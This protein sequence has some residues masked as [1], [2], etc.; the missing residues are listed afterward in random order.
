MQ[1]S[2]IN[3]SSRIRSSS[4][5]LSTLL[6]TVNCRLWTDS[7]PSSYVLTRWLFLR[8]LGVVYFTAFLSLWTQVAGLIGRQGILPAHTLLEAVAKDFGPER[9]RLFPTW[10]WLNSGDSFL[11][12]LAAGGVT[13]SALVIL[14]IG[15]GPVLLVLW[16]FY[17]SL[18]TIGRDFL[19]FQWDALLLEAGFL[20]IFFAPWQF[21][22]PHWKALSRFSCESPPS[23][24]ALWLWRWLL[25]RLTFLSGMVKLWSGDPVW[26]HLTALSFHYETQPLPTPIAWYARQLPGW[27]QK[28]SVAGV[29][30]L[31]LGVPFLIFAPRRLRFV[32]AGLMCSLQML[33][34]VTGNYAFFNLLTVALCLLLLDDAFLR[35]FLPREMLAR[36]MEA[37]K[38][39]K[40]PRFHRSLI[41]ALAVFILCISAAQLAE[42]FTRGRN[43]PRLAMEI[44]RWFAPFQT[45]NSYGLFAVM[46]TSRPEII[47]EGSQDGQSWLEYEFKYKPGDVKR[48]SRWVAPHQPRLDWQ[49]W[50][51]AL[52]NYQENPWFVKFMVRLLEG[53]PEVL[54][55]L[56]KNPFP[57]APP[58]YVRALLYDYHFTDFATRKAT[59]NWWRRELK[60]LY[61]PVASLRDD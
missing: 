50:F 36:L 14:G 58:R 38:Q 21:F 59:G 47:V 27:F 46:T 8:L 52:G 42:Q 10:A 25:F 34:A 9:Y 7:G 3:S 15:T 48:A 22:A 20:S 5:R 13:L 1:S 29:F 28:L 56:S 60:R 35:R 32:G 16:S 40:Y 26:R 61:F 18:V 51:A 11:R 37:K 57:N 54:A 49:M 45:V 23:T 24:P 43:M 12:F 4:F 55:L 31:E 6:S 2:I 30:A 33:I 39:R 41:G 44:L 53:S 17:L 19:A